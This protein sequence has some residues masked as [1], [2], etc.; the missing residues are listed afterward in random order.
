MY[1]ETITFAHNTYSLAM[2]PWV[3]FEIL[4]KRNENV[5]QDSQF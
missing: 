5:T 3:Q 4:Y 1:I 2:Y